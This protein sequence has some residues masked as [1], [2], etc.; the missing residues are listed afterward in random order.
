MGKSDTGAMSY[1]D[2]CK[3]L[4]VD[5]EEAHSNPQAVRSAYKKLALEF[6]PDKHPQRANKAM[7]SGDGSKQPSR[8]DF[9]KKF[10]QVVRAYDA[11]TR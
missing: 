3:I 8:E 5:P 7:K 2:A 10:R 9:E 1:E 11:L 4:N 6:H